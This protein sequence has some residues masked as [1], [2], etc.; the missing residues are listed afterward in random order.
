VARLDVPVADTFVVVTVFDTNRLAKTGVPVLVRVD[1]FAVTR[2]EVPVADTFVVVTVFDTKRLLKMGV[3]VLVKFVIFAVIRF[4]IPVADILVVVTVFDTKRLANSGVPVL[5]KVV[6]FAMLIV[7]IFEIILLKIEFEDTYILPFTSNSV[8]V[9][10][11]V[12]TPGGGFT[13]RV[14]LPFI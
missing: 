1:I 13:S 14:P 12:V 5:V 9:Y 8:S 6:I 3:S 7:A 11:C 4:E 2:L 10:I